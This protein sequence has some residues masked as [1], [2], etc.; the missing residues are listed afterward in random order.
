MVMFRFLARH[1][2]GISRY[3]SVF[4]GTGAAVTADGVSPVRA[5]SVK[6]QSGLFGYSSVV[7]LSSLSGH[8]HALKFACFTSFRTP[9]E[10]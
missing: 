2:P 4:P 8:S 7:S 1:D 9:G 10:V 3:V 6:D 5:L